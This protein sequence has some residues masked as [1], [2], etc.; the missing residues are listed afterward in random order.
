MLVEL[1]VYRIANNN[2]V[3]THHSDSHSNNNN[4]P[5]TCTFIYLLIRK[6][7]VC[8]Y[9]YRYIYICLENDK[10]CGRAEA[11]IFAHASLSIEVTLNWNS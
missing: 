2:C 9:I 6:Y 7:Y 8:I 5:T 3:Y 4:G 10:H 11:S 1:E